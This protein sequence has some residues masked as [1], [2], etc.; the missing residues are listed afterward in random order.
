[1]NL[2]ELKKLEKKYFDSYKTK[3]TSSE[4]ALHLEEMAKIIREIEKLENNE[5]SKQKNNKSN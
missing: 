5:W 4:K 3:R 2:Q 1:M